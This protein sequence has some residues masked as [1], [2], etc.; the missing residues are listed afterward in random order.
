MK[1]EPIKLWGHFFFIIHQS[2]ERTKLKF[3]LPLNSQ[4]L[5]LKGTGLNTSETKPEYIYIGL[6]QMGRLFPS[7]IFAGLFKDFQELSAK[8]IV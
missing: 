4:G 3:T 2:T 5:S 8:L 7:Q 1:L 6:M